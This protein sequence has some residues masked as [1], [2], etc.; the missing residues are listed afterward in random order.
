MQDRT[1]AAACY[2]DDFYKTQISGSYN[3]ARKYVDHL[4]SVYV[5]QTVVDVGCG[6]GT[7]LK[8]FREKGTR[9][10]VGLDGNWNTQANMVDPSI[11]FRSVDL[12]E[13]IGVTDDDRYDLAISLEVAEHLRQS[14]AQVFVHSLTRLSDVVMFGA[15]YT[16]QGGT[17][18]INEQPP[19]YWARMFREK[20]YLPFDLFRPVFWGD[21]D[22]EFWYQ[23]NTFLYVNSSSRLVE[24]LAEKG[25]YPLKNPAFMDCVHPTLYELNSSIVSRA[26]IHHAIPKSLLPFARMIKRAIAEKAR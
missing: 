23:Q 14:S 26:A 19:T 7:W 20:D 21:E 13:P 8:A 22:V 11:I 4:S 18:H 15:A 2:G 9:K 6:R 16:R 12:N 17:N 5:P 24:K 25:H 1:P 3:S 10:T